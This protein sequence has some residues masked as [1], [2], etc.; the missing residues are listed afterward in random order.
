MLWDNL[1]GPHVMPPLMLVMMIFLMLGFIGL[2]V[3]YIIRR[4]ALMVLIVL[5]PLAFALWVDDSTSE[6]TNLWTRAFFALVF[7]EFVHAVIVLLFFQ[8]LF[9][10][11]STEPLYNIVLCFALLYLMYK[12]PSYIFQTT[13]I[14]WGRPGT[15]SKIAGAGGVVY[16]GKLALG[17]VSGGAGAACAGAGAAAKATSAG[18]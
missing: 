15:V 14:H 4:A 5:A 12:I 11:K 18:G 17:A 3:F 1:L 9:A 7:V 6:Y 8:T 16:G 2:A 10:A 13:V